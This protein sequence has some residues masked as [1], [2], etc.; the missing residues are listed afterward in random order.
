MVPDLAPDLLRILAKNFVNED[1]IVKV[2]TLKL[3]VK[4]WMI[5]RHDSE[6]LVHYV[7]QLARYDLSYD[8]RDSRTS[9]D[10]PGLIPRESFVFAYIERE[11]FQLG[12]LSHALNQRCTR[13]QDL[14]NFPQVSSDASMRREANSPEEFKYDDE[15]D[16]EEEDEDEYEDEEYEE[17]EDEAGSLEAE[18]EE[19]DEEETAD[20]TTADESGEEESDEE[21]EEE[22]PP[23]APVKQPSSKAHNK[24]LAPTNGHSAHEKKSAPKAVENA[25]DLLLDLDFSAAGS[26]QVVEPEVVSV[27]FVT[28]L[29]LGEPL[30]GVDHIK[31]FMRELA[32]FCTTTLCS[33][34]ICSSVH[35]VDP[36]LLRAKLVQWVYGSSDM[37]GFDKETAFRS[38]VA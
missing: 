8:V 21:S 1:E 30:M 22:R 18:E 35:A 28:E 7:L 23:V 26:R 31:R 24:R 17:D 5:R 13:Y 25:I 33:S 34:R 16:L 27:S 36:F 32:S 38:G 11:Q 15:A 2:E 14:P 12:T 4:L 3:A 20:G 37:K 10:S 19:E 9:L 6:K 29:L